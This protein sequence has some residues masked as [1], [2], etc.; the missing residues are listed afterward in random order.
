[1][2]IKTKTSWLEY[3]KII[4]RKV[5]FSHELFK[6]EFTKS[7]DMLAENESRELRVWCLE[8]FET[9]KNGTS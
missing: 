4:L 1:M 6:K 8:N 2:K 9:Q 3:S 5:S 7:L